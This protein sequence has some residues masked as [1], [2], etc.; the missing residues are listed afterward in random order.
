MTIEVAAELWGELRRYVNTVDRDE[1]ADAVVS[2]LIDNDYDADDIR[3]AFK[4]D[5]DIKRALAAYSSNEDAEEDIEED[6]YDIDT[7]WEE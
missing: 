1:A 6:D 4:G 5:S 2:I 3:D 7:D